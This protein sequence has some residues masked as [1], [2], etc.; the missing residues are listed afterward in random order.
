MTYVLNQ[1]Q[2]GIIPDC[3][4]LFINEMILLG[5]REYQVLNIALPNS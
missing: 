4:F 1:G 5:K 3:P 2:F